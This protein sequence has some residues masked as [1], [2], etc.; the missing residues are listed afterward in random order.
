MEIEAFV[1][2]FIRSG[3]PYRP[4]K[5]PLALVLAGDDI[6]GLD[7]VAVIKTGELALV[8]QVI[9]DL[10]FLDN[11]R[12]YIPGGQ[13][14]IVAKK[15]LAVDQQPGDGLPLRRDIA[16]G[17]DLHA[18]EFLQLVLRHGIGFCGKTL[19]VV[20]YRILFYLH[21]RPLD[22]DLCQDVGLSVQ[23]DRRKI[24]VPD[25]RIYGKHFPDMMLPLK[26]DKDA[27]AARGKAFKRKSPV[28]VGDR[29]LQ[30]RR[31]LVRTKAD[32]RVTHRQASCGVQDN[33]FD[34]APGL[35]LGEGLRTGDQAEKNHK[36]DISHKDTSVIELL[37]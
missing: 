5:I 29:E 22:H 34:R 7:P 11:L 4:A 24:E 15:A 23:E 25:H 31:V 28:G 13:L 26:S 35:P 17:V 21:R 9:E 20:F 3:A 6:D 37:K 33:A 27:I 19:R 10:V 18:W 30:V 2:G 32:R 16:A 14:G 12:G 8:I 36:Y 1:I